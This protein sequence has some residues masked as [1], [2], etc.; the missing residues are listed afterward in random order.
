V[1]AE[2][3]YRALFEGAMTASVV[4]EASPWYLYSRVAVP[5]I[6]TLCPTVRFVVVVRH[7]ID[8]ALSLYHHHKRVGIEVEPTFEAA[9]CAQRSCHLAEL[10]REGR[11]IRNFPYA[12][13]C[14]L[15]AQLQRLYKWVDRSRVLVVLLED[16]AARPG[17]NIAGVCGFLGVP[18]VGP[19]RF[20]AHNASRVNRSELLT[21]LWYHATRR[22]PLYWSLKRAVNRAGLRP[23]R[24][25]FDRVITRERSYPSPPP[26][27]RA[28]MRD[29]FAADVALLAQLIG[30]PL[31]HW[32]R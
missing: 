11:V 19:D 23:G 4:G 16:L 10:P 27:L 26:A 24:W 2:E 1:T 14:S 18:A 12:D 25:L 6:L 29:R 21:R 22:T 9:W 28:Q 30:R 17:P 20:V 5:G 13:V 32:H 8:M 7:P 31:E 15:G 3:D